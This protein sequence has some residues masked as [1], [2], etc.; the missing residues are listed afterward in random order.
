[1]RLHHFYLAEA[2]E[3]GLIIFMKKHNYGAL[4]GMWQNGC[5]ADGGYILFE[6]QREA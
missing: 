1:M 4:R 2:L 6:E 5:T 3:R